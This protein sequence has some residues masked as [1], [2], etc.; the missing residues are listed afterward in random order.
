MW[1]KYISREH[2]VS[3]LPHSHPAPTLAFPQ[4]GLGTVW[5]Q[6]DKICI[7]S[8]SHAAWDTTD[9]VAFWSQQGS[10]WEKAAPSSQR[11]PANCALRLMSLEVSAQG[12][13]R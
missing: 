9:A 3:Y 10:G 11:V 1:G 13:Q 12:P 4:L 8:K 7:R 5:S 6:V 2:Y